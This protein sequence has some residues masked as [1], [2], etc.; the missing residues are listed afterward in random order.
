MTMETGVSE[1]ALIAILSIIT[2]EKEVHLVTFYSCM[3]KAV[4]LNYNIYNKEL[5]VVFKAFCI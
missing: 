4:K 2:E 1:Y 3:F 5:F